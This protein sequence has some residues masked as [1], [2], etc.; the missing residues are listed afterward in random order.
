MR[1][2][3]TT[4]LAAALLILAPAASRAALSPYSQNFE[5][6][7]QTDPLA[8]GN[9]GWKVFG[10]VF[11]PALVY[12]YGYGPFPAPNGGPGFSGIDV[13]QGG[14]PQ[15]NQQLVVYSDYNN[16]DHANGNLI[17]SNVYREQTIAAADVGSTWVFSFD[18]KLGNLVS[19]STALAFIKTLAL[20]AFTLTNFLTV[21]TTA[22]PTTWGSFS[23]S[24]PITA[25]L[26]GQILQIGFANTTTNYVSSGVYY[27]NI[28]WAQQVTGVGGT[29]RPPTFE[30]LAAAPNPFRESTRID[31]SMTEAGAAD[32]S[33]YDISGRHVATLLHGQAEPGS[34]SETWDGRFDD[35]RLAPAGI[36][37]CVLQT[38]AGR[39]ARSVVFTR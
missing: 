24:I 29:A 27:D 7:V 13:G 10:N 14:P 3:A 4:A 34:H 9:N 30:L 20:P 6:L 23:I 18:A 15:G 8:L 39:Q 2:R 28:L 19:P 1:L 21:N 26:V 35:G 31:Y 22:L 38:A 36:Y 25:G 11:T 37:R 12:I 33:V 16:G 5:S 32:V 17:E